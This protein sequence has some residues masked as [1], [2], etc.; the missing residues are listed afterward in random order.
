MT[1]TTDKPD[2][3]LALYAIDQ[4][5]E[6]RTLKDIGDEL[7]MTAGNVFRRCTA[8]P[9][10]QKLYWLGRETATDLLETELMDVSRNAYKDPKGARVHSSVLQWLI[11][12]RAPH[13][14]GAKLAMEH[15]SP[16]GSMSP[17]EAIDASKLS[18][19]TLAQLMAARKATKP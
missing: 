13:R 9:A 7:G 8:T 15:T 14:F 17:K 1:D 4:V 2:D 18:D 10:L 12:K 5:S 11:E 16:D 6:G 3:E 19:E